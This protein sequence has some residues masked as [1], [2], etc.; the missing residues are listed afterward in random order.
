MERHFIF[1]Q[2]RVDIERNRD[3][4]DEKIVVE[5]GSDGWESYVSYPV[6]KYPLNA[7]NARTV[8]EIIGKALENGMDIQRIIEILTKSL[9]NVH[10]SCDIQEATQKLNFNQ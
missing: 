5:F 2:T 7:K 4:S 10:Q 9:I 1:P 8:L 3:Y 6:I